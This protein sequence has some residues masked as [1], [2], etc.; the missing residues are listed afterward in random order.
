HKVM[1]DLKRVSR[2][3]GL[4]TIVNLHFIDMAMEYAD[5]IIGLRDGKLVFDGPIEEVTDKTFEEIYDRPSKDDDLLGSEEETE[6]KNEATPVCTHRS[7]THAAQDLH[8]LSSPARRAALHSGGIPDR[9]S[10]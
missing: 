8:A 5:R 1:K 10:S 9:S 2:E 3:D 7:D 6:E 4:T